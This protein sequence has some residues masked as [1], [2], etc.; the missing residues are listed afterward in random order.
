MSYSLIRM[1]QPKS[2]KVHRC[3]WCAE[4]IAV[5]DAHTHE[6]SRYDGTLQDHR[7]HPECLAAWYA[8]A[9]VN[10]NEFDKHENQRPIKEKV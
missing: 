7:W 9:S 2:K 1:T 8:V 3:V 5:G 6:V 4:H 10:E